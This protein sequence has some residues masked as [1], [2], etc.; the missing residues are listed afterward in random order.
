[1]LAADGFVSGVGNLAKVRVGKAARARL[2]WIATPLNAAAAGKIS[3]LLNILELV[4]GIRSY[5]QAIARKLL[6]EKEDQ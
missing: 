1:M 2:V 4:S 5:H 3:I 6:K